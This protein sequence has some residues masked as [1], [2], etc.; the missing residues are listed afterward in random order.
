M[1]IGYA[2][3]IGE[4]F[5]SLVPVRVVN[6]SY[7]VASVY[8]I[9]HAVS[10]GTIE[11]RNQK[12]NLNPESIGTVVKHDSLQPTLKTTMDTLLW[13]GLAS[14]AIPGLVVNRTCVL[15]KVILNAIFQTRT[16]PLKRYSVTAIGLCIIPFII[17]PI[18][19]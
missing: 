15:S 2:N 5:R 18:D 17:N 8:V 3:E 10:R 7:L 4:A 6:F 12:K 1:V 9:S 14:V 13:Q 19:K 16:N 11:W